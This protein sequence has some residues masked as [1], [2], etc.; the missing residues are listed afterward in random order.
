VE[1]GGI[2]LRVDIAACVCDNRMAGR[3]RYDADRIAPRSASSLANVEAK[4]V[5]YVGKRPMDQQRLAAPPLKPAA[6]IVA[7]AFLFVSNM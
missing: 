3:L 6:F 1:S 7:T 5:L 4:P 2:H